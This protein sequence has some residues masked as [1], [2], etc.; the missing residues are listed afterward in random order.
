MT[1]PKV[2]RKIQNTDVNSHKLYVSTLKKHLTLAL[3][4]NYAVIWFGNGNSQSSEVDKNF[5][6]LGRLYDFFVARGTRDRHRRDYVFT[7]ERYY[8]NPGPGTFRLP[9]FNEFW[10]NY[11]GVGFDEFE[12]RNNVNYERIDKTC[13]WDDYHRY[14]LL[15]KYTNS[16]IKYLLEDIT[17]IETDPN[18]Q[19]VIEIL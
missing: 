8:N 5:G 13:F 17:K 14:R 12:K 4:Q 7:F 19:G 6:N 15:K 1:K 16:D 2:I 18:S 3:A 9:Y 10:G 11:S